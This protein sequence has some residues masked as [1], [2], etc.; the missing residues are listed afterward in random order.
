MKLFRYDFVQSFL[1]SLCCFTA[2][3]LRPPPCELPPDEPPERVPPPIDDPLEP[4]LILGE[5]TD[6]PIEEPDGRPTEGTDGRE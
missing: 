6:L 5:P 3:Y 2:Y 4:E 1:L